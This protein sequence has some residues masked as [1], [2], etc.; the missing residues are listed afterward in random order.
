MNSTLK[1]RGKALIA[2]RGMRASSML[3]V[4]FTVSALTGIAPALL[5]LT[6]TAGSLT[7][8]VRLSLN[9]LIL[10]C[11]AF[12]LLPLK[13]GCEAWFCCSASEKEP[14]I[15]QILYWYRPK[16]MPRGVGLWLAVRLRGL[17]WAAVF[18][19]PGLAMAGGAAY[20]VITEGI[21]RRLLLAFLSGTALVLV[22]GAVFFL[23]TVQR[24]FLAAAIMAKQPA[25]KPGEAIR[26][27]VRATEGHCFAALMFKL[28]FA[29]WFAL[30]LLVLPV[31]YVWPYYRQACTCLKF[32]MYRRYE[33]S[34][35]TS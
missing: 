8:W 6:G 10:L 15:L 18:F 30:C 13:L 3:L 20:A 7:P 24:Y 2:G 33:M 5:N 28:S 21:T 19:L 25:I 9:L 4:S 31:F 1:L 23:L 11:A 17:G 29:P 34:R 14:S 27:S 32:E 22:T 12:L 35:Y 26:Q 16:R